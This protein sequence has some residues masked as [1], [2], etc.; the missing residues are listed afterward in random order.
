VE[1][2]ALNAPLDDLRV[3][4]VEQF[5]AGPWGTLQ[6]AD[7]GATVVKME[8]PGA[9]GDI[10]R[11]VPPFRSGENSLFFESFN[12]ARSRSRWTCVPTPDGRCSA[13]WSSMPT[14]SPATCAET[15]PRGS[16]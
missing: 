6:L 8:D 5:G 11:C 7:L 14:R 3:I 9:G 4:A 13:I 10:G 1:A 2:S 12:P 15:S 16:A